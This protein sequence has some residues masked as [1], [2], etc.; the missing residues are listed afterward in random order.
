MSSTPCQ[1]EGTHT[2]LQA[3]QVTA[4]ARAFHIDEGLGEKH[5]GDVTHPWPWLGSPEAQGCCLGGAVA[6][7]SSVAPTPP[8]PKSSY[9]RGHPPA[10]H[11]WRRVLVVPG[12]R[13]VQGVPLAP[14][15]GH[16]GR[17]ERVLFVR[18]AQ[19]MARGK[20]GNSM[21]CPSTPALT[22]SPFSPGSPGIPGN[23]WGPMAPCEGNQLRVRWRGKGVT[24]THRPN[25]PPPTPLTGLPSSPGSP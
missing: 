25:S 12:D 10:C 16:P 24:S 18:A 23:P 15:L 3:L 11:A 21:S 13:V 22:F 7:R 8:H 9:P 1:Q 19:A 2:H 14:H 20:G 6:S 5:K 17:E 4:K